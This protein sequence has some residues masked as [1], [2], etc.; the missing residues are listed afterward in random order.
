[1]QE[2]VQ[3]FAAVEKLR[4]VNGGKRE[5]VEVYDWRLVESLSKIEDTSNNMRYDVWRHFWIGAA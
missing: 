4:L 1:M 5:W 2:T 3:I